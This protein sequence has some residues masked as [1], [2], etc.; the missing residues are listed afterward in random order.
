[1][2]RMVNM[3]GVGA[4][5]GSSS[6]AIRPL[7]IRPLSTSIDGT[8]AER[9]FFFNCRRAT[10]GGVALHVCNVSSFWTRLA[11]QL[12]HHDEAV[13]HALVA[14][15]AAHQLYRVTVHERSNPTTGRGTF[16]ADRLDVFVIQQYNKA[17]AI[18]CRRLAERPGERSG[19][20]TTL[21]LVCCL[22]FICLESL[23][24][25]YRAAITHLQNGLRVIESSV[26]LRRLR[27]RTRSSAPVAKSADVS[28]ADLRDIV[29]QFRNTEVCIHCFSADVPMTLGSRFYRL[30]RSSRGETT[31]AT[32]TTSSLQ[33]CHE[34]RIE[35]A[36]D[37]M[38]RDW[39]LRHRKGDAHFWSSPELQSELATLR[40]RG[41][42]I[43]R[44]VE[45]FLAGP[46]APARGTWDY[47]SSCMDM[48]HVTSVRA[49]VELMPFAQDS[50]EPIAHAP[51]FQDEFITPMAEYGAAMHEVCAGR[52]GDPPPDFS[53]ETAIIGPMYWT[54]V[55]ST[56]PSVRAT[57]LRILRETRH[58][59][60]PWDAATTL[61]LLGAGLEEEELGEEGSRALRKWG[62][63]ADCYEP[64]SG[65]GRVD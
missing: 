6:L 20:S 64:L 25:N 28:D 12:S 19:E 38:S 37:I 48:L 52:P 47:Y 34:A 21:T 58:R 40:Q 15:G 36:S 32:L 10:E 22:A 39:E 16:L 45:A 5:A 7:S 29:I 33:Q 63:E 62:G 11:P 31:A 55:Y 44:S 35:L 60:G 26:D 61:Q 1:M 43:S 51:R 49:V 41:L 30:A 4:R 54:Y 50:H 18:L 23:R 8:E 9:R 27:T 56:V 53:L 17:I 13:K 2:I 42:A 3:D 46:D 24:A 59:E 65:Q 14:L 57:V